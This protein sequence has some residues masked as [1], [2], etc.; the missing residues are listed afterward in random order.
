MIF[1]ALLESF[2]LEDVIELLFRSTTRVA[3]AGEDLG[4]TGRTGTGAR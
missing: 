4:M 2:D 3:V 1:G